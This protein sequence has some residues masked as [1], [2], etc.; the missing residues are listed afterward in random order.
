VEGPGSP[1]SGDKKEVPALDGNGVLKVCGQ[2]GIAFG[3]NAA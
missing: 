3:F 1:A 2:C